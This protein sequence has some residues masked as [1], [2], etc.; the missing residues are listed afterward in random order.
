[1]K[2]ME[3]NL[4]KIVGARDGLLLLCLCVQLKWYN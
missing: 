2:D 3:W 1:M 4:E